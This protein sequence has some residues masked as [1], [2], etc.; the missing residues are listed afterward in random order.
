MKYQDLVNLCEGVR[1]EKLFH[2]TRKWW[3]IIHSGHMIPSL[4][5]SIEARSTAA[6][7]GHPR[8]TDDHLKIMKKLLDEDYRFISFARTLNTDFINELRAD[9]GQ[10]E[11]LVAYE[12]D[13]RKLKRDYKFVLVSYYGDRTHNAEEEERLITT[14]EEFPLWNYVT[15]IH[16]YVNP[17]WEDTLERIWKDGNTDAPNADYDANKYNAEDKELWRSINEIKATAQKHNIPAY[18]Y[19]NLKDFQAARWANADEIAL[20]SDLEDEDND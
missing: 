6:G 11:L 17:Y 10:S 15:G 2:A 3:P 7:M 1:T 18:I 5:G 19:R 16:A 12:F 4:L 8:G 14:D 9:M 13:A 20:D